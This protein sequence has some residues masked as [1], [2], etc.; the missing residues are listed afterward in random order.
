L[1]ENQDTWDQLA[2]SGC[3][4]IQGYYLSRPLLAANFKRWLRAH[5]ASSLSDASPSLV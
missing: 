1:V 3:D 5:N 4:V 2:A